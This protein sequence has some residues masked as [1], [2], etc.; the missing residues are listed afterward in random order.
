M[1]HD[2]GSTSQQ[3][4][5]CSTV[6]LGKS[7]RRALRAALGIPKK[8]KDKPSRDKDTSSS[9]E[10]IGSFSKEEAAAMKESVVRVVLW[11][12]VVEVYPEVVLACTVIRK[13]PPGLCL[14]HPDV[15]RNPHGAVLRPLEPL[16]PGQ[17]FLLIP[18]STVERLK[19]KIPE[20]SIGA[21]ADEE[22]DE[23]TGSEEASE[24]EDL[25][26]HSGGAAAEEEEPPD[27][28]A[29]CSAREYFVA[30]DRWSECRFRRLVRQGIAVEPSTE[31]DQ[32]D[33]QRKDK[34]RKKKKKRKGK[35][36]KKKR[37]DRPAAPPAGLRVFATPRRTWEPSLP[38]VVEEESVASPLSTLQ[39][40]SESEDAR[41]DDSHEQ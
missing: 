16:F 35:G 23:D 30:R 28:M 27:D 24:S 29:A 34:A 5:S 7:V 14:A 40:P 15:F 4:P 26:D 21:F 25:Q 8:R 41:I 37:R 10:L 2:D 22:G 20:G 1:S 12:G 39:H 32:P 13:H 6:P 36:N 19:Q 38:P 33:R 9:T 3:Q 18:W 31:D 11:S 17:K